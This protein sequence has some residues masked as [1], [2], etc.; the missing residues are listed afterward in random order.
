M[1]L[2]LLYVALVLAEDGGALA[3]LRGE[4]V[5]A[6]GSLIAEDS[7][8]EALLAA[9]RILVFGGGFV[10]GVLTDTLCFLL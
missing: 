6:I 10:A 5:E 9:E 4:V 3:D 7:L 1:L 2:G 8:F